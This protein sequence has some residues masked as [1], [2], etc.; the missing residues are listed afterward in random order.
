MMLSQL[1]LLGGKRSIIS[2]EM[3]PPD[4][5]IGFPKLKLDGGKKTSEATNLYNCIAWSIER[6]QE[7]WFEPKPTNSWETWPDGIP[8][9]YSLES[10]IML[11]E[12]RGYKR[13]DVTDTGFE[14]FVKKVAIYAEFGIYGPSRWEFTHVA[15]QLNCGLWTSK[16][17]NGID[18]FHNTPNSLEG[19][20][21]EEYGKIY[22][23]LRRQC[24]LK[25]IL[26]RL[27][28]RMCKVFNYEWKKAS[29]CQ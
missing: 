15:D 1:G 11:F 13:C 28:C 19:N 10:F 4:V 9:D 5:D 22:M 18:I 29:L 27:C 7:K 21:G 3:I 2:L 8:N 20:K 26:A 12:K 25:E 17:G 24:F 6:T 23:I 14:F 16:L